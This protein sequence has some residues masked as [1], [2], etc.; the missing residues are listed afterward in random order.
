MHRIGT[1]YFKSYKLFSDLSIFRMK[2][3]FGKLGKKQHYL[4]LDMF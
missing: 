1:R 4:E 3:K 2:Q